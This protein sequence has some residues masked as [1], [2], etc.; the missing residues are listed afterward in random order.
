MESYGTLRGY[1]NDARRESVL[2]G[3]WVASSRRATT[4]SEMGTSTKTV[5]PVSWERMSAGI[6][7]VKDRLERACRALDAV[8]VVYAVIGGKGGAERV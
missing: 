1:S 7:K 5:G 3:A 4:L 2:E 6:E 8:G